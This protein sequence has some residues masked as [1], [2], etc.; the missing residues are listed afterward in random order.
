[1]QN[2]LTIW[3]ALLP[4]SGI[5][6]GAILQYVFNRGLEERRHLRELRTQA[7]A[8]YIKGVSDVRHLVIQPQAGRERE[9]LARLT[10]A[11]VR[12]CLYAPMAV[13]DQLAAFE[14]LGGTINTEA[15]QDAFARIL[16]A[17]R[18]GKDAKAQELETILLGTRE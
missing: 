7:Y 4:V 11:K 9:I 2:T 13:I 5:I 6:V 12:V 15:Q 14:R 3:L 10:E 1:V 8:D 16:V 17:M 18:G